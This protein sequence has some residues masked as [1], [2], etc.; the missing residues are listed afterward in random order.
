M[1]NWLGLWTAVLESERHCW[2][3]LKKSTL[4]IFQKPENKRLE[5]LS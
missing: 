4:P 5:I 2:L 3:L 1:S